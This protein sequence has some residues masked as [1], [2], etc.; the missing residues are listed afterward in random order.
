MNK[1]MKYL[2]SISLRVLIGLAIFL[3]VGLLV[4]SARSLFTKSQTEIFVQNSDVISTHKIT[5]LPNYGSY[6]LQKIFKV[7]ELSVLDT[8][9]HLQPISKYTKGKITLLTFFYDRCSDANGCPYAMALF[10]KVKSKL[11][12][13][14]RMRNSV[15]LVHISFDPARDTPMMMAGLEKRSVGQGENGKGIE[16]DFLT[17]ASVDDL[18]PIVNSFGQNVDINMNPT[19]GDKTLTYSH[20]LKVFLIDSNGNVREIYSTNYI[21]VEMLLNDVQTLDLERNLQ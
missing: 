10:H 20:V 9:G 7:P 18:L 14:E 4:W 12:A 17:T 15:R 19:L 16:W 5:G 8:K 6:T 21:S 2:S 3:S 11:E 13:N 1:N